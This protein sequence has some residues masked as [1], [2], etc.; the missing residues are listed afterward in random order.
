MEKLNGKE[1]NCFSNGA[2]WTV[3]CVSKHNMSSVRLFTYK[4]IMK[5]S[6]YWFW[7]TREQENKDAVVEIAV[8]LLLLQG[9]T[10]CRGEGPFT[11]LL[12]QMYQAD[13]YIALFVTF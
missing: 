6:V 10:L 8:F 5:T 13:D 2:E 7:K 12:C 11:N 1:G 9:K 3:S 4:D